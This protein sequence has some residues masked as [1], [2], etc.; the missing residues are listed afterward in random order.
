MY[1]ISKKKCILKER[2]GLEKIKMPYLRAKI[3]LGAVQPDLMSVVSQRSAEESYLCGLKECSL[4]ITGQQ[5]TFGP[6]KGINHHHK[7]RFSSPSHC[8]YVQTVSPNASC[9]A[10]AQVQTQD[11]CMENTVTCCCQ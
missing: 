4:H 1:D 6:G 7:C 5:G 8:V 3:A 2:V 11:P 10:S 9:A